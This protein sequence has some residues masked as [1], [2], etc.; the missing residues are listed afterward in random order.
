MEHR[1]L[2]DIAANVRRQLKSEFPACTFS[3][4]IERF[5]LGQSMAVALMSAPFP[6]F[7]KLITVNGYPQ[8]S[9]YAQLNPYQLRNPTGWKDEHL[10]NGSH[11]TPQAW[12]VLTVA[13]QISNRENWNNSDPQTDYIS[14]NY[15]FDLNIGKWNRPFVQT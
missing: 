12:E 4:T 9:G 11:L 6:V 8:D 7:A 5:S 14:N 13:D 15:F 2:K 3:V 1:D 10:C